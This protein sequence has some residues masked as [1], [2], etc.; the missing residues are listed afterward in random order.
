MSKSEAEYLQ[1]VS[2]CLYDIGRIIDI[3]YT[4]PIEI[5]KK[6]N[7]FYWDEREKLNKLLQT[8][9]VELK[10][11]EPNTLLVEDLL[12]N[13]GETDR[14]K[15]HLEQARDYLSISLAKVQKERNEPEPT[16]GVEDGN[17]KNYIDSLLIKKS[18]GGKEKI[19]LVFLGVR[20]LYLDSD[21]NFF[22]S[23][24]DNSNIYKY[25]EKIIKMDGKQSSAK[26]LNGLLGRKFEVNHRIV[27][28]RAVSS[29]NKMVNK[30]LNLKPKLIL[31]KDGY[32]LNTENY[33]II[34]D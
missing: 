24:K 12:S 33:E 23:P 20:G 13:K 27:I 26:Q 17:L 3:Y 5:N 19:K 18:S 1:E 10:I 30:K 15:K 9:I 2:Q 22:Y 14:A 29:I 8:P 32:R 31:G 25:L 11:S 7:K 6:L 4:E 16:T 21:R 28:N 34:S